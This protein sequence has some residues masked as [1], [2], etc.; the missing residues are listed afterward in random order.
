MSVKFKNDRPDAETSVTSPPVQRTYANASDFDAL[1]HALRHPHVA[2]GAAADADL[3]ARCAMEDWDASA[4]AM[5][6]VLKHQRIS[7]SDALAMLHLTGEFLR[8]HRIRLEGTPWLCTFQTDEGS[9]ARYDV[10]TSLDYEDANTWDKRLDDV[11]R[12]HRL[13]R[14]SFYLRLTD[15]GPC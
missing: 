1:I 5:K 4:G 3:I 6:E 10:H 7:P 13:D 11:L 15:G 14:D 9:W 2:F 8:R 12:S